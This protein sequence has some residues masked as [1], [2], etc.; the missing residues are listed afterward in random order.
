MCIIFATLTW[1]ENSA[2]AILKVLNSCGGMLPDPP[3][4]V[5]FHTLTFHTL[6]S[7]IYVALPVPEQ[8]PYSG[9]ATGSQTVW[10]N[11][12]CK[13]EHFLH[14]QGQVQFDSHGTR[15]YDRIRLHQYRTNQS[16]M[17][18]LHVFI[19]SQTLCTKLHFIFVYI[20]VPFTNCAIYMLNLIN[21]R[22]WW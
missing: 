22:R 6:R 16:G 20:C 9:Y 15:L 4:R 2:D 12:L 8:L 5:C 13:S 10:R 11:N 17:L 21:W 14:M 18:R 7:T 1:P 3:K 19:T